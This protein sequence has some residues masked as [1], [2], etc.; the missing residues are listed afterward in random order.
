M[1]YPK[2]I[3]DSTQNH[4]KMSVNTKLKIFLKKVMWKPDEIC[5]LDPKSQKM[6]QNNNQNENTPKKKYV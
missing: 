2:E 1:G 5:R 4:N 3:A 6:Y